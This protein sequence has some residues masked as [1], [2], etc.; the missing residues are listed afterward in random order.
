MKK[1]KAF[2][3]D[4]KASPFQG[5]CIYCPNT[6]RVDGWYMSEDMLVDVLAFYGEKFPEHRFYRIRDGDDMAKHCQRLLDENREENL[7][8]GRGPQ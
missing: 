6:N 2:K 5:V 8:L 3:N 4:H 7:I 1:P